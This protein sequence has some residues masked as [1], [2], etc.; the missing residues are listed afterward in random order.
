MYHNYVKSCRIVIVKFSK[1]TQ[2]S[3]QQKVLIPLGIGLL[4]LAL[5]FGILKFRDVFT[6]KPNQNQVATNTGTSQ[7]TENQEKPEGQQ[8]ET[9]EGSP[10]NSSQSQ[11]DTT[12]GQAGDVGTLSWVVNKR[13]PLSPRDY[14]PPNLVFPN[15]KLRVPG[16]ESMRIRN[17]AGTAIEQLFAAAQSAGHD[18]MFSSGYRSYSYQVTLYNSYVTSQGQAEADKQSARPGYS[19]HQTGLA[20]D[21]CNAGN[22]KLEQAFGSTPLGQWVAAHAHEYGFTIRYKNG[23]EHITGYIYEPWHLRYVGTDLAT[24]LFQSGK[25]LEEHFGLPAA[26]NYN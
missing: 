15:V 11:N 6:E 17:D 7:N 14:V 12:T 10:D 25:T 21:I 13:R 9:P 16:N 26:P 3:N 20:F 19:E 1:K 18:P 22:C 4:A 24:Q 23:M 2:L 8:V 5:V